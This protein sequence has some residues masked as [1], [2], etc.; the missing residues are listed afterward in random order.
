MG[1]YSAHYGTQTLHTTNPKMICIQPNRSNLQYSVVEIAN[2]ELNVFDKHVSL[3]QDLSAPCPKVVIYCRTTDVVTSV[4]NY[5]CP[6]VP[7]VHT[8]FCPVSMFHGATAEAKKKYALSEF[9]KLDSKMQILIATVAFGMGINVK[10]TKNVVTFEA[11]SP[12]KISS[13]KVGGMEQYFGVKAVMLQCWNIVPKTLV[14]K[15]HL[16][17]N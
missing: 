1:L 17:D 7:Y 10:D 15:R 11:H 12:W 13:R 6:H 8:T 4:W 16:E 14:D 9:W 5:F 3:V 2:R